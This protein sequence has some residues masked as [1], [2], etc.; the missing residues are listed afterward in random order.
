[1][2][3]RSQGGLHYTKVVSVSDNLRCAKSLLRFSIRPHSCDDSLVINGS[4]NTYD[5]SRAKI[6]PLLLWATVPALI[7]W[8]RLSLISNPSRIRENVLW[9]NFKRRSYSHNMLGVKATSL[10]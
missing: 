3:N 8:A 9:L 4:V 2:L 5:D 10:R 6:I 7:Y 1:M